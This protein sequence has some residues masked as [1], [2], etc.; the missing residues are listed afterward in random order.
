MSVSRT[1][2]EIV[3]IKYSRD[4]EMPVR[5]RSKSLKRHRSI[6]QIRVP[7]GVT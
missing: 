2:Y 6:D 5:D 1:V 4:L 3:S 7:I